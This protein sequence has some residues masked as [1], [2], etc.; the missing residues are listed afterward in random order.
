MTDQ[1]AIQAVREGR[2][3]IVSLALYSGEV[4][5]IDCGYVH[6]WRVIACDGETDVVECS[7][8][9]RQAL[10]KCNFEDDVS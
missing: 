7:C 6:K 9:G 3:A 4:E 8:C 5:G 2:R 1:E 10:A